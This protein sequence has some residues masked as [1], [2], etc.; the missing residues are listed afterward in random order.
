[1]KTLNRIL[2]IFVVFMIGVFSHTSINSI[3]YQQGNYSTV[4]SMIGIVLVSLFLAINTNKKLTHFCYYWIVWIV[5]V[6]VEFLIGKT[7][8]EAANIFRMTFCP[9]AFLA[10]YQIARSDPKFTRY[11]VL[12]IIVIFIDACY[13]FFRYTLF[14]DFTEILLIEQQKQSNY[15]F[16]PFCCAPFLLLIDKKLLKGLLLVLLLI[17]SIISLKRSVIIG[18]VLMIPFLYDFKKNSEPRI[19]AV[20]LIVTIVAVLLSNYLSDYIELLNARMGNLSEDDGS[21]RIPIFK[22]VWTGITNLDFFSLVVGRGFGK[23]VETGYSNAHNDILQTFYEYGII[24]LFLYFA[25]L[26]R[27]VK[28]SRSIRIKNSIFKTGYIFTVIIFLVMGM[29]SNLTV[30]FSF[31]VYLCAF[32]GLA[33]GYTLADK[34]DPTK[35]SQ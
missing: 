35:M 34:D 9:F 13:L 16:W 17:C 21:G 30:S 18:L 4:Y 28:N 19:I 22:R 8:G 7:G 10:F 5:W 32:W 26:I 14:A 31:F 15:I 6:L 23:I 27:I 29:V 12:A 11:I 2:S 33:E 24:G 20:L 3:Y 1:M 25:L